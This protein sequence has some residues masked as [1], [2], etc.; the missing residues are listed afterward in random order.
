MITSSYARKG[1]MFTL[2]KPF[3]IDRWKSG[4]LNST[5][6]VNFDRDEVNCP[7]DQHGRLP[8][9]ANIYAVDRPRSTRAQW[10]GSSAHP[11]MDLRCPPEYNIEVN[12]ICTRGP[13]DQIPRKHRSR[14]VGS[15][16]CISR[17]NARFFGSP[18][19]L[20]F[21]GSCSNSVGL[22]WMSQAKSRI[23]RVQME[24]QNLSFY[25]SQ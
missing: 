6:W 8:E 7:R 4:S 16:I 18:H 3:L 19:P 15:G 10:M 9:C 12:R 24:V 13:I 17:V 2:D 25:M 11:L 23:R 20:S 5:I 1:H 21:R 14:P 22:Q